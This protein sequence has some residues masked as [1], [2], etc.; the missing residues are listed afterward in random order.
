MV[1]RIPVFGWIGIGAFLFFTAAI[2]TVTMKRI[3]AKKRLRTHRFLALIG[4]TLVTIHAYLA[5][6]PY[7]R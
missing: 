3:P 5:L 7:L 6:R 2:V 4:Y 1:S